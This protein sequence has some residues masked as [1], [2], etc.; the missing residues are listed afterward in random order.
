MVVRESRQTC[1]EMED[2]GLGSWLRWGIA[3]GA[4]QVAG[5]VAGLAG[6][7]TVGLLQGGQLRH[8]LPAIC[9]CCSVLQ[10]SRVHLQAVESGT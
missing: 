9:P 1:L 8:L 4:G 6:T 10:Y 5:G 2:A 3:A 7:T